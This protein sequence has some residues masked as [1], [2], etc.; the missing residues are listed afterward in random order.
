MTDGIG[1]SGSNAMVT[2]S[3]PRRGLSQHS[4]AATLE[5]YSVSQEGNDKGEKPNPTPTPS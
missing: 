5:A 2:K 4:L 1:G 3:F